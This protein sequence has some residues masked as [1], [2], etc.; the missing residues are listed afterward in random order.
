MYFDK[1]SQERKKRLE[2]LANMRNS[3]NIRFKELE[4]IS[5]NNF[6]EYHQLINQLNAVIRGEQAEKRFKIRIQ[7]GLISLIASL[8]SAGFFSFL[9]RWIF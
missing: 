1:D 6:K 5:Q 8:I 3:L 7:E 9:F 4:N 2:C